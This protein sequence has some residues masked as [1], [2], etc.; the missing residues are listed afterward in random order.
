[1]TQA[2]KEAFKELYNALCEFG[3]L[4]KVLGFKEDSIDMSV[5]KETSK[6]VLAL[7]NLDD[8]LE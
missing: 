4:L 8:I 6:K 1:M 2:E 7:E 3:S 5:F